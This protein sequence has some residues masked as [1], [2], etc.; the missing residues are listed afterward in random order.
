MAN[1][2]ADHGYQKIVAPCQYGKIIGTSTSKCV[3]T[4]YTVHHNK[5][6]LSDSF[7]GVYQSD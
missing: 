1:Y 7:P 5:S 6:T 3:N 2:Y 4:F